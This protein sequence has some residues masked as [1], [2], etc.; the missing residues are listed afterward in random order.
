[1]LLKWDD[2][3]TSFQISDL[4]LQVAG[5]FGFHPLC[6][7]R[8]SFTNTALPRCLDPRCATVFLLMRFKFLGFF[9]TAYGRSK[10]NY[11]GSHLS[12]SHDLPFFLALLMM[13]LIVF[14][15]NFLRLYIYLHTG[16][17]LSLNMNNKFSFHS[18]VSIVS[19]CMLTATAIILPVSVK[20]YN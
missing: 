5:S 19:M 11:T 17:V 20:V 4:K 12:L 9:G 16:Y 3:D 14:T 8:D 18:F 13:G 10:D 1:M 2:T 15:M 7:P 6:K